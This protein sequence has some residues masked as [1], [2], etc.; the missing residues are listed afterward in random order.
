[1]TRVLSGIQP[2]GY[3]HLGNFFG[4]MR[5]MIR[6]QKENDLFSFIVNY[7]AMTT[8][9]NPRILENNTIN[10]ALDFIALGLDPV[11]YTHLTLPTKA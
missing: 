10:A 3:I 6:Y 1:M 8:I 7:H 5:L 2:S 4:M 11:S 9:Q